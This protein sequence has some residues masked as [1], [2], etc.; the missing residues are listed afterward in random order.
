MCNDKGKRLLE[1]GKDNKTNE[2]VKRINSNSTYKRSYIFQRGTINFTN[3]GKGGEY[4]NI[5]FS[6]LKS[7]AFKELAS[8]FG[9]SQKAIILFLLGFVAMIFVMVRLSGTD[10]YIEKSMVYII[11]ATFI[12]IIFIG[13]N[14]KFSYG[15]VITGT[16]LSLSIG[17]ILGVLMILFEITYKGILSQATLLMFLCSMSTILLYKSS[18]R[19]KGKYTRVIKVITL[20]IVLSYLCTFIF[21]LFGIEMLYLH[22]CKLVGLILSCLLMY[23][24]SISSLWSFDLINSTISRGV[25]KSMEWY[26]ASVMILSILW[27]IT[28]LPMILK[29]R[30]Y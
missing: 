7:G 29:K 15:A 19:F 22:Q 4:L 14:A 23:L 20:A 1:S 2:K 6:R 10:L 18:S 30:I 12:T 17:T 5:G 9:V 21:S 27:S 13:L 8:I 28:Q 26:C 24:A 25:P 16:I 11:T 3:E